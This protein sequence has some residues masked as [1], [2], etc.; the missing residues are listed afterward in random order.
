MITVEELFNKA[1]EFQKNSLF[2]IDLW[3]AI[4]AI[5]DEYIYYGGVDILHPSGKVYRIRIDY[6]AIRL[7]LDLYREYLKEG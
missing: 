4:W 1:R 7:I 5:L 6:D 2:E 3:Q